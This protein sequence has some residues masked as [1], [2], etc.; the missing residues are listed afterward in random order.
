[1]CLLGKSFL[2]FV[3]S[4]L[5]CLE[6]ELYL[7]VLHSD[8]LPSFCSCS[9][10]HCSLFSAVLLASP[11]S[12]MTH[13]WAVACALVVHLIHTLQVTKGVLRS[14]CPFESEP[15]FSLLD[16]ILVW[17]V[18]RHVPM[19]L[20]WGTWWYPGWCFFSKYKSWTRRVYIEIQ[21][22]RWQSGLESHRRKMYTRLIVTQ[23]EETW[24]WW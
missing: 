10:Y 5:I 7:C 14:P 22:K 9:F 8:W 24:F 1:M 20:C 2:W 15:S 12:H 3:F 23:K 17:S 18:Q 11:S 16:E 21:K 13:G 19:Q 6:Q 4:S